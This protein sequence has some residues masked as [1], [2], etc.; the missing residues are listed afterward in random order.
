M[1]ATAFLESGTEII[2]EEDIHAMGHDSLDEL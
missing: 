1:D 2:L